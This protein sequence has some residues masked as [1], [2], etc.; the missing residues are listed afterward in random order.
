RIAR[1]CSAAG[2]AFSVVPPL[3]DVL[4]GRVAPHRE[5]ELHLEGLLG[6]DAV[7][8]DMEEVRRRIAGRT[9]LVTGGAGSIGS[10]LA[11]HIAMLEPRRLVLVDHAESRLY[12]TQIELS[13]ANPSLDLVTV[14]ANVGHRRRLAQIFAQHRPASP[15]HPR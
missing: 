15:S 9:V 11:R 2:L 3:R 14:V 4:A 10:E 12:F 6:R 5:R 8:L 7:Q 1:E 13:Q